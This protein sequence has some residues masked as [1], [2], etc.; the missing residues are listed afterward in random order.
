M[1][2]VNCEPRQRQINFLIDEAD[3]SGKGANSVVSMVHHYLENYTFGETELVLHA[4]NCAGQNKN[5]TMMWYLMWRCLTGLNERITLSFLI[6]GHTKF[7]PDRG[8]GLIKKKLKVTR[9]DCLQDIADV[10]KASS[11]SNTALLVGAE[12]GPTTVLTYDWSSGLSPF[13]SRV[14]AVKKYQHFSFTS[15]GI[16]RCKEVVDQAVEDEQR[17]LKHG[18]VVSR[19]LPPVVPA[20]GLDLRRQWYLHNEIRPFVEEYQDRVAPKPTQPQP[21]VACEEEE[22]EDPQP[23]ATLKKRRKA[24]PLPQ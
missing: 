21:P 6:T 22:R 11:R 1:G 5:S 23:S 7:S 14:K 4:D 15:D 20:N 13:F 8:F 18:V 12:N 9:V 24:T 3:A 17:L 2:W 16:L 10:V 19:R